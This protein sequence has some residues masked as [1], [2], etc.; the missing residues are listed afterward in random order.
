MSKY[1]MGMTSME[2]LLLSYL[3]FKC[4]LKTQNIEKNVI[5]IKVTYPSLEKLSDAKIILIERK[6]KS[7]HCWVYIIFLL[8]FSVSH[9][10]LNC[11]NTEQFHSIQLYFF[12]FILIWHKTLYANFKNHAQK[13]QRHKAI[14]NHKIMVISS[15]FFWFTLLFSIQLISQINFL[16]TRQWWNHRI[17]PRHYIAK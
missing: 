15:L 7:C 6:R 4:L 13:C 1:R 12:Y 2:N 10:H 9:Y 11:I 8:L 3:K 17:K 5:S 14:N 16:L